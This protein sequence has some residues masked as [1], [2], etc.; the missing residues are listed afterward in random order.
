LTFSR[1]VLIHVERVISW[2]R[3]AAGPACRAVP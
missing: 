2:T 1:A 3:S